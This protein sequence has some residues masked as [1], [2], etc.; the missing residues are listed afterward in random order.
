M[1]RVR[2]PDHKPVM[3][4]PLMGITV[5]VF[6]VQMATQ[7][8]LGA[9]LPAYF[10]MK[11]NESIQA[12]QWWRFITPV[13]LHGSIYHI[14]FNMYALYIFGPQLESLYGHWMLLVLYLVSNFGGVALSFVFTT[15]PSLGASTAIFGLLGAN[16]VFAYH[17]RKLFGARADRSLRSMIMVA[18]V[19]LIIG[20]TPGIDNWGHLGGLIAGVA[21]AWFGGPLLKITGEMPDLRAEDQRD[22]TR[23]VIAAILTTVIFALS[24]WWVCLQR[25]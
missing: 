22:P 9:D 20:M 11:I 25:A 18:V 19:N 13:F 17:N 3:T 1:V 4:Y 8:L 15:S 7:Y 24:A 16:A 23:F 10:G 6:L 2:M 14:G 21:V 5:V 12:G